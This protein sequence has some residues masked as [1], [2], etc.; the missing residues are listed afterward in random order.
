MFKS[1]VLTNELTSQPENVGC[2][3][4]FK[5]RIMTKFMKRCCKETSNGVS[6]PIM[7]CIMDV[8]VNGAFARFEE[9]CA[10]ISY[11][12]PRMTR[13]LPLSCVK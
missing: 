2:E 4:Q 5:H 12:K 8:F 6:V 10:L 7:D 11:N 9:F 3:N 13:A 1:Y